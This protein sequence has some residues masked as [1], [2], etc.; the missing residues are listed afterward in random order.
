MKLRLIAGGD[1]C[2]IFYEQPRTKIL[3]DEATYNNVF[4]STIKASTLPQIWEQKQ[5]DINK[6]RINRMNG[7]FTSSGVLK[8]GTKTYHGYSDF[9]DGTSYSDNWE[10]CNVR[11]TPEGTNDIIC[12][13]YFST[14]HFQDFLV[15]DHYVDKFKDATDDN[16][17]DKLPKYSL[18]TGYN[19]K[20]MKQTYPSFSIIRD[21]EH[22]IA[23]L[24][25][26]AENDAANEK[27]NREHPGAK[28]E[29]NITK[30][31]IL[32]FCRYCNGSGQVVDRVF[33]G[34]QYE[35]THY[36]TCTKCGGAGS[37]ME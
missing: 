27:Y 26:K 11:F 18:S 14:E 25:R 28:Q 3:A 4:P 23:S 10:Y 17:Y 19:C 1:F 6:G 35:T 20:L 21:K 13:N 34:S 36:K 12:G 16:P 31:G 33:T 22:D 9:Y 5:Q 15:K 8:A 37:W 2:V 24:K 29:T 30:K 7:V 32:T